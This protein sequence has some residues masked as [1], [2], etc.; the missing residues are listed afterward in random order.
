[1]RRDIPSMRAQ[2]LG[3]LFGGRN[4]SLKNSGQWRRSQSSRVESTLDS[5]TFQDGR[6]HCL[7]YT[8]TDN[9]YMGK[10]DL[11]DAYLTVAIRAAS[12]K[13]FQFHWEAQTYQYRAMP[14]GLK[15]APYVFTRLLKRPLSILRSHGIK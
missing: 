4:F 5:S 8:M 6:V 2:K 7:Q 3:T 14:F 12:R 13:Y 10:I 11:K 1:M 15:I 9:C